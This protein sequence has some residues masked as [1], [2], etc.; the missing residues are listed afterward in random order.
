MGEP[1]SGEAGGTLVRLEAVQ[2]ALR[3][4][5][6]GWQCRLRQMAVRDAG[7]RPTSGL[8]PLPFGA[9]GRIGRV[10]IYGG[11]DEAKGSPGAG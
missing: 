9:I 10:T 7:G 4:H 5:F 6:L 2:A 8:R 3:D 11:S 1:E